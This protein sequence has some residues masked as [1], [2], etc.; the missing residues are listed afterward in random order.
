MAHGAGSA[1]TTFPAPGLAASFQR[2]A[3]AAARSRSPI[4]SSSTGPYVKIASG[5]NAETIQFGASTISLILRSAATL[6]T[7]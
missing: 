1:A 2:A 6:A 5:R 7:T 4:A 3:V